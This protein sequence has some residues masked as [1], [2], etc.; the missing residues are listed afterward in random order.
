MHLTNSQFYQLEHYQN[1]QF[2]LNITILLLNAILL[3][4]AAPNSLCL[5]R[6]GSHGEDGDP[7]GHGGSVEVTELEDAVLDEAEGEHILI[8]GVVQL[9]QEVPCQLVT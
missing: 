2:N 5:I 6:Q 7:V 4:V 9:K 8:A 3:N 1:V